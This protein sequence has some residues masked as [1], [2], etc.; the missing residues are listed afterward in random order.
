MKVFTVSS[1]EVREGARVEEVKLE[2]AGFSFFAVSVGEQGRGRKLANLPVERQACV[3]DEKGNLKVLSAEVGKTKSGKPKMFAE[4]NAKNDRCIVVFRTKIG[5]RGGNFHTGDRME[6]QAEKPEFLP[7]PGEILAKGYI[8]QGDAGRMGG[9]D[10]LIAV[11]PKNVVFRTAYSGR[12]YGS[13]QAHY[14]IYDGQKIIAVT[15]EERCNSD[16]F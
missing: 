11:I 8:A 4:K 6:A 14:Y 10:Q 7:F 15:W 13:P 16:I 5:F 3:A 12:L 9:G 2:S 1:G